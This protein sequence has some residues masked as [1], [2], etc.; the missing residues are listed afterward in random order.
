MTEVLRQLM[1]ENDN[2]THDLYRYL[3]LASVVIAIL[4]SA[5]S[6]YRTGVFD[7]SSYG[8]GI[9]ALFAGLGVQLGLKK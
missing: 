6:V 9:G 4:L 8:M 5:Y 2:T 7:A 3:A 1:T